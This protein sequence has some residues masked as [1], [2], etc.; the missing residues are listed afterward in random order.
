MPDEHVT[1]WEREFREQ[2]MDGELYLAGRRA[3]AAIAATEWPRVERG[4]QRLLGK[5]MEAT[6]GLFGKRAATRNVGYWA[7]WVDGYTV[8]CAEL[9]RPRPA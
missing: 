6:N 1:R 8:R 3:G 5:G 7:G 4:R 2:A 9:D